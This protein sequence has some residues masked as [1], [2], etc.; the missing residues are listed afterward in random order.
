MADVFQYTKIH[1]PEN[2]KISEMKAFHIR[3]DSGY[4]WGSAWK[5]YEAKQMFEETVFSGLKEAGFHLV[6]NETVSF[7]CPSI[8]G[9]TGKSPVLFRGKKYPNVYLHPMEFTGYASYEM[10]DKIMNVL[11]ESPCVD[12]VELLY[13]RDVYEINDHE[14]RKILSENAPVICDAI[15][16]FVSKGKYISD[17]DIGFDFAEHCRIPRLG[18]KTGKFSDDI[19]VQFIEDFYRNM[20][21]MG[22]LVGKEKKE[23]IHEKREDNENI[24]EEDM[25]YV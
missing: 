9:E 11:Q 6:E 4:G 22:I 12:N 24:E 1:I 17:Y 10:I 15:Q 7:G 5:S 23:D 20:K 19:D 14:Y 21:A 2:A 16:D 8:Q 25:E 3:F 13:E 18:D